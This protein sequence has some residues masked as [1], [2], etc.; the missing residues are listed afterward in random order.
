M[1]NS[2]ARAGHRIFVVAGPAATALPVIDC[3]GV[4]VHRVSLTQAHYYLWRLR[5]RF[6][7]LPKI[8]RR[9]EYQLA[10]ALKIRE[11]NSR[12]RV[13]VVEYADSYA[14]GLFHRFFNRIPYV[15][16][17]HVPYWVLTQHY[18]NETVPL[19]GRM[20]RRFVRRADAILSPSR[21]L[22]NETA[23]RYRLAPTQVLV[24]ANPIDTDFFAPGPTPADS[25]MIILFVGWQT[26]LK[27][28]DVLAKS[29]PIVIESCPNARFVFIG[30]QAMGQ[31]P[32]F[33]EKLTK[34][35]EKSIR[36]GTVCFKEFTDNRNELALLYQTSALCV[37]PSRFDNFPYVCL[38]AMSCGRAVV[39]SRV[40]GIPEI[41][42]DGLTGLLV[43]AGDAEELA[44]VLKKIVGNPDRLRAMGLAGRAKALKEFDAVK[45]ATRT[46]EIYESS[47]KS[48]YAISTPNL[49]RTAN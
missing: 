14:D 39:A 33:K 31:E 24:L 20:E 25:S 18:A 15:V 16:K 41:I 32:G 35:L 3:E 26:K 7:Q 37:V 22:A 4:E 8:I 13:D 48:F 27:G 49:R 2:L 30:N 43:D 21:F 23:R 12:H 6:A 36:Q 28:V 5:I 11:L 42:D 40:G 46:V 29:I 1:A 38:E 44:D 34:T 45:I 10:I 47:I 9:V 17:V 19:I